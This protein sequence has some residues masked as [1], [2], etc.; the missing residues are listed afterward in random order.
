MSDKNLETLD[1]LI[2]Q[3]GI[4]VVK[5]NLDRLSA[6]VDELD[7]LNEAANNWAKKNKYPQIESYPQYKRT[8]EI[9]E[10][11]YE[12]SGFG[13]MQSAYRALKRVAGNRGAINQSFAL[14]EYGWKDI[15]GWSS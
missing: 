11:F 1:S 8:R 3:H 15:G 4:E 7:T 5:R 10:E 14:V 13:G 9:G 12:I 6:L 2:S